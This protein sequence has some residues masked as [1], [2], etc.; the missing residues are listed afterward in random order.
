[1]PLKLELSIA[2]RYLRA[3]KKQ[4][5]ISVIA[6]FSLAGIAL[7]VATLIVVMSVMNGFR[8]EIT[9]KI[10]GLSGHVMISSYSKPLD[11]YQQIAEDSKEVEGVISVA[12]VVDGQAIATK[13]DATQGIIVK[14]IS[15]ED[16]ANR[17]LLNDSIVNGSL[18][19]YTGIDTVILGKQLSLSLGA[20]IDDY[21]TLISPQS[22][23]TALGTIPR[24]KSY[25]VVA[26]F[27]SGMYEYDSSFA[28]IPLKAAQLLFNF[29]NSVSSVEII[30]NDANNVHQI[31]KAI[32]NKF[33]GY[34]TVRNWQ[35][36]NA[37]LFN[38]LK[39]ERTVMFLILTLIVCVAAFNIIS[40]LI[41]LV[42]DKTSDI[43][44]LRTMGLSK[45]AIIRIFFICGSSIGI[46]GTFIGFVLGI[47]F[48]LNVE[49][50]RK[51]IESLTG[52]KIFDPVI[53]FL[54]ELPVEIKVDNVIWALAVGLFFSF[55]AT[56]YPA[57]KAAKKDPAE[58]LRYG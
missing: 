56:I 43:A 51:F 16:I 42:N 8:T 47:S 4:G 36:V 13:D 48:A 3:K 58:A 11:N 40:S 32:Y 28:F 22:R 50:I 37:S 35:M 31:S 55:L 57:F 10:L 18:E 1:M 44:I 53:Y 14:G 25:R 2:A 54:S 34:F 7:G 29:K 9:S 45:G 33:N 30:T 24:M 52:N 41:M 21:V 20:G 17:K 27:N 15:K 46:I 19:N 49:S 6:G 23:S 39:I 26:I 12:S 5:V 38:A